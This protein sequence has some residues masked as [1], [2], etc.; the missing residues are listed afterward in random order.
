MHISYFLAISNSVFFIYQ[1]KYIFGLYP[2]SN[3]KG[4]VFVN[5][6]SSIIYIKFITGSSSNQLF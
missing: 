5:L 1:L 3:L 4:D 6:Y 2:N